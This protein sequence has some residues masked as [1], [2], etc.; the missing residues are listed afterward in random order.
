LSRAVSAR[1]P[2]RWARMPGVSPAMTEPIPVASIAAPTLGSAFDALLGKAL[3]T[4]PADRPGLNAFTARLFAARAADEPDARA[5]A[6]T[7]AVTSAVA[8]T[9]PSAPLPPTA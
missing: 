8:A 1:A 6:Q 9:G 3:A 7:T 5:A 2:P 4:D